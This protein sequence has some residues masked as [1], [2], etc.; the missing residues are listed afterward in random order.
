[1]DDNYPQAAA[2]LT[3]RSQSAIYQR[4]SFCKGRRAVKLTHT[5]LSRMAA[6]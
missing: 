4:R 1:M 6:L 5:G 3:C 2:L